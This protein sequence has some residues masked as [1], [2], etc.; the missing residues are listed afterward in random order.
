ML[1]SPEIHREWGF[2]LCLDTD[3]GTL[4]QGIIDLVFLEG[5]QW[6]LVDYKTDHIEDPEAFAA[7][8]SFQLNWYAEAL[9]RITGRKVAQC[10]LWSI[11]LEQ[12]FPVSRE[13]D[14]TAIP[15]ITGGTI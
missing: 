12:A 4:L 5:D 8:H 9:E 11:Q 10:W 14:P 6:I 3:R 2:N 15:D 1:R 13:T 7:H